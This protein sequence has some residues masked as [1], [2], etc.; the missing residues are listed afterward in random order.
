MPTYNTTT[1]K[2]KGSGTSL[3]GYMTTTFDKLVELLGEPLEGSDDGK[4]TAEWII[5]IQGEVA[6]IYDWKLLSNPKDLYEW[7][8]G[9]RSLEVL[10]HLS[11]ALGLPTRAY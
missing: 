4:T 7:H 5:E 6:T 8:V 11:K 10:S 9:G 1:D 2:S 3:Q